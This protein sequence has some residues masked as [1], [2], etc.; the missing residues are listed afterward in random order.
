M[1]S[2]TWSTPKTFGEMRTNNENS[3]EE[4]KTLFVHL[5]EAAMSLGNQNC[6]A[7]QIRYEALLFGK[8]E[9]VP[10]CL[11]VHSSKPGPNPQ[12]IANRYHDRTP[13]QYTPQM[14]RA[15]LKCTTVLPHSTI[16]WFFHLFIEPNLDAAFTGPGNA[17][18]N[19]S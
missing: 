5:D 18:V 19:F 11:F 9:P 16:S 14:L 1:A 7:G 10:N 2:A 17:L 8:N 3:V 4:M 15:M 6:D 12:C 13:C